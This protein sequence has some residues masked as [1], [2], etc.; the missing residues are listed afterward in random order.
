MRHTQSTCDS[1]ICHQ[2]RAKSRNRCKPRWCAQALFD[3]GNVTTFGGHYGSL[4]PSH[5][6]PMSRKHRAVFR[7]SLFTQQRR[8]GW[9]WRRCEATRRS[10]QPSS[11]LWLLILTSRRRGCLISVTGGCLSEW[12]TASGVTIGASVVDIHEYDVYVDDAW[13]FLVEPQDLKW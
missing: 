12:F 10:S 1:W 13:M 7:C 8:R 11:F 4:S 6:Q 3:L 5:T 9:K 2:V